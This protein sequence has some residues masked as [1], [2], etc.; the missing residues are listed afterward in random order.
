MNKQATDILEVLV[1]N[2]YGSRD[3]SL[4]MPRGAGGRSTRANGTTWSAS[5]SVGDGAMI[6]S[7]CSGSPARQLSTVAASSSQ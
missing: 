1:G 4:P 5:S 3:P 2:S 7:P 6:R